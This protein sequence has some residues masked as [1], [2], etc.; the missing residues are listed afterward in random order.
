MSTMSDLHQL[1][2]LT[3]LA[4]PQ[5]PSALVERQH[6]LERLT[7][8]GRVSLITAS[9]G[10]GKTTLLSSL[11]NARQR[12]A[13]LTLDSNDNDAIRFARYLIVALQTLEPTLG[14]NA[15][16]LLNGLQQPVIEAVLT[17]LINEISVA[18]PAPML[19]V[20]DDYHWI[21]AQVV[22]RALAWLID[23]LPAQLHLII[24]SRSVPPLPLGRWRGKGYLTELDAS[25]LQFN[26]AETAQLLEQTLGD[27][28]DQSTIDWLTERTEGWV[29]G[30]QLAALSA[31]DRA[32]VQQ[33]LSGF[34]GS[35]RY[36]FD[37]LAEEVLDQL[38]PA[39]FEFLLATSVAERLTG[40]LCDQLL[41]WQ[42]G[43][44][45][46]M[47]AQLADA[48]L[49]LVA[50]DDERCW[51]RYHHLFAEFLRFRLQQL[52]PQAP[53]E[54]LQRASAW[55]AANNDL[56]SA[57]NYSLAAN[58]HQQAANLIAQFGRDALMRGEA[59]SVRSWLAR[60][61]AIQL[62]QSSHLALIAAWS[63]LLTVDILG[64]EE[65]LQQA[66]AHLKAL[67]QAEQARANAE[68]ATIEAVLL[69][70]GDNIE[71][72][73]QHSQA[74]LELVEHD[75]LV[76][77]GILL[78]N[79]TVSARLTGNLT[80]AV[81][82]AS[83][84]V[85]INQRSG[86]TFAMLLAIA[87]LGQ[88]QA[89]Q[90]HLRKAAATY[91]R[92]IELASER[93]WHQVPALGLIHVG[94]GEVCYEWNQLE[95]AQMHAE[96]AITIAQI[97]G[98]LDIA[99]DGYR[100][101]ARVE[102]AKNERRNSQASIEQALH[103]AQRNNVGRFINEVQ[104]SQARMALILG[105]LATVRRWAQTVQQTTWQWQ[106]VSAA[107]TYARWLIANN[108][109]AQALQLAQP[110]LEQTIKFGGNRLEWLL[111]LALAYAAQHNLKPAQTQLEQALAISEQEGALRTFIDAG[112]SLAQL[113]REGTSYAAQRAAIVAAMLQ[114]SSTVS[115][116]QSLNEP[117]SER[118]I[119]VLKLLALGHSNAEIAERL[120]IAI[121]TVKRHVNNLLGKLNA[122]SRTEA[123][124]IA[125]DEG[126]LH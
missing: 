5:I 90:G 77:R 37:Y 105:D 121:G 15:M 24:A 50:L 25:V 6:V 65:H 12:V 108:E 42:P 75:D 110:L 107:N 16:A 26:S 97:N 74:A 62:S 70:F 79:L 13:W 35:H 32:N 85:A 81:A 41:D 28:P 119:E 29:A 43:T 34:S 123:V 1:V 125:R 78:G 21:D 68:I 93:G 17:L 39:T 98:Y 69:R 8:R 103:F 53:A 114:Q 100:L 72:S 120:V 18:Q 7:C 124:A 82:A 14:R 63:Q 64:I 96:Q 122:R 22:H 45:A 11:A 23:Q 30:I 101:R 86:N 112:A 80:I 56:N 89:Q 61:P 51:Y 54:F 116:A 118:E 36:I 83:D 59:L 87:D 109:P 67:P 99:T 76:L 27:L 117:L 44:G 2:L 10:S 66:R 95:E 113:L 38:D 106:Q 73:M 91:R 126:L 55:H 4:A 52:D 102:H 58:D 48:Q 92:G 33:V 115:A 40:A 57:I 49:F 111:T 46:Q 31:K 84:A 3:K 71:H 47:L 9:A 104:A 19:L 88:I 94:L 60:L 20:L